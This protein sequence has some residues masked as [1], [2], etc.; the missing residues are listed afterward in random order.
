MIGLVVG[1]I[2]KLK[3]S[4]GLNK[5]VVALANMLARICWAVLRHHTGYRPA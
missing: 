5:T 1:W 4:H 2:N 3:A